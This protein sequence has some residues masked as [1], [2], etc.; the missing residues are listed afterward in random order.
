MSKGN[1]LENDW[2]KL[3]FNATA[4]ADIAED[5]TTSPLTDLYVA[6]HATWP[7][8]TGNQ[9]T[10]EVSYT[11][12]ARVAVPRD[13][14][15]WTVTNNSVSP[16][17]AIEFPECSGST[18]TANFWSVG[19]IVSGAGKLLY[20]GAIG[21]AAVLMTG[22]TSDTITAPAHGLIVDDNLVFWPAFGLS[23][24]TGITEG[25]VYFVKTAPT[26][27]TLTISTTSGGS[28]VDITASG[29]GVLQ[30]VT[31]IDISTGVTPILTTSTTIVE[32]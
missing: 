21:G 6:L 5:D 20:K 10:G 22:A 16:A 29:P 32:D 27:D 28:T 23:L 2:L 3:L 31:P 19:T 17:A 9:T 4:I 15:G 24:P 18:A 26:A 12:Y 14:T 11:D 30:K 13:N 1:T 25:T 8:E 7:G